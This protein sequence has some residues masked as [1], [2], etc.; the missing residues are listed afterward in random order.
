MSAFLP[1]IA[2]SGDPNI[3]SWICVIL[4]FFEGSLVCIT[5]DFMVLPSIVYYW[6]WMMKLQLSWLSL[7]PIWTLVG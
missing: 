7:G 5:S 1:A 2:D 4:A 3:A 6:K